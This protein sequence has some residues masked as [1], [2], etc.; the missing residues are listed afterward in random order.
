MSARNASAA[1]TV[2]AT[3]RDQRP[4]GNTC[5]AGPDAASNAAP[6]AK[7]RD[8][9]I[10]LEQRAIA[11]RRQFR[12]FLNHGFDSVEGKRHHDRNHDDQHDRGYQQDIGQCHGVFESNEQA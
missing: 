8:F 4:P 7:S 10:F 3:G 9:S 11:I 12:D 2:S 5:S 1:A 6:S